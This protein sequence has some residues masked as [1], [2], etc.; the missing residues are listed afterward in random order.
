MSVLSSAAGFQAECVM[1]FFSVAGSS[2]MAARNNNSRAGF[3]Q[4]IE[5]HIIAACSAALQ[6]CMQAFSL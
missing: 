4:P 5:Q 6:L 2:A 3:L 1:M